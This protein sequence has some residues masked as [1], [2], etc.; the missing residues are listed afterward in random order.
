MRIDSSLFRWCGILLLGCAAAKTGNAGTLLYYNL[1]DSPAYV[2]SQ[3]TESQYQSF[4]SGSTN[5]LMDDL[6]LNLELGAA[7]SG[8]FTVGLYSN[9][10]NAPSTLLLTIASENDSSLS[11]AAAVYDF[12]VADY[13]L[14]ANTQYWIGLIPNSPPINAKWGG[15]HVT[16]GDTGTATQSIDLGGTVFPSNTNYAFYMSVDAVPL[17]QTG[18][19]EPSSGLLLA[20]GLAAAWWA[21]RVRAAIK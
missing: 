1:A 14:S 11:I 16:G 15:V 17:Q 9:A 12:P 4:T 19:P 8:S 2:Y 6:Q 20:A 5:L 7:D 13:A 21:R 10:S 3:L 18:T